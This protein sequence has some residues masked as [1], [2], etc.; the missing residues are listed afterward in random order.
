M[1]WEYGNTDFNRADY[2]SPEPSDT[3]PCGCPRPWKPE[4]VYDCVLGKPLM[5]VIPPEGIHLSCPVHP[6]GHHVYGQSGSLNRL[7]K[8]YQTGKIAPHVY[9]SDGAS[10]DPECSITGCRWSWS[11]H[12][13]P[14][15]LNIIKEI[16]RK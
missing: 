10:R 15:V 4:S 16:I 11:E 2:V 9:S 1:N 3:M 13:E 5:M 6:A 14:Q 8:K 7:V 12:V